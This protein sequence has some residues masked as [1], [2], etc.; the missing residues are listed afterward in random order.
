MSNCGNWILKLNRAWFSNHISCDSSCF[1]NATDSSHITEQEVVSE[2]GQRKFRKQTGLALVLAA[3]P[4][5]TCR[6]RRAR[7]SPGVK[8]ALFY[9]RMYNRNRWWAECHLNKAPRAVYSDLMIKKKA[10]ADATPTSSGSTRPGI[11]LQAA[12]KW[13]G[14]REKERWT[15]MNKTCYGLKT[16]WFQWMLKFCL[17]WQCF[18]MCLLGWSPCFSFIACLQWVNTFLEI[19]C[20]S[21]VLLKQNTIWWFPMSFSFTA[22]WQWRSSSDAK[23][24]A[25]VICAKRAT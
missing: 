17:S 4:K 22:H 3:V 9:K 15:E 18:L 6:C 12:P 11:S 25:F 8:A 23:K 14:V 20:K 13:R 24:S 10:S 16:E 19:A 1:L 21:E 2:S 7:G 5:P